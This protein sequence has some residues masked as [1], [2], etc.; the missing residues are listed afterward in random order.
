VKTADERIAEAIAYMNNPRRGYTDSFQRGVAHTCES[1]RAILSPPPVQGEW[2]LT[3]QGGPTI[4]AFSEPP[5]MKRTI[6][7]VEVPRE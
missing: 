5:Q 4:W 6:L 3:D 1:V 2:F 7:S